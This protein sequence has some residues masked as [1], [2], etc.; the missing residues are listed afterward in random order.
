MHPA[1]KKYT[2]VVFFTAYAAMMLWEGVITQMSFQTAHWVPLFAIGALV[3]YWAHKRNGIVTIALLFTHTTL[4][5]IHHGNEV[6]T[7][8]AT[9]GIVLLIHFLF[10]C[11]F[12]WSELK[13]HAKSP[14]QV[15]STIIVFYLIAFGSSALLG[16]HA[17][18]V[19]NNIEGLSSAIAGGIFACVLAHLLSIIKKL[20]K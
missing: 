4:E 17:S 14:K 20:R 3:T 11:G 1:I 12:L 2:P 18:G 19:S 10:D 16:E 9:A 7:I 5:L 13:H 8:T 6:A 15:F